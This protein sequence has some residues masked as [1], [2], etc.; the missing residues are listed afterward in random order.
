MR[1]GIAIDETWSFL[2]EIYADLQEYHKVSLFNKRSVK[3][4]FFSE[5]INRRLYRA[6]WLSFL[7]ENDVVFFEWASELLIYATQLPK[8]C[9]IVTRLH[10]YELYQWADQVNWDKVDKIILVSKAKQKEFCDRFPQQ[11]TKTLVIP[12]AISTEKFHPKPKPFGRNIGILCHL[13]PRKRVYET[14]LGFYELIQI[15]DNFSLHIAGGEHVLHRDYY[16][17]LHTIVKE[18]GLESKVTF[19][20]NITNPESWYEKIDIFL[21]NSYSEGLQVA[22]M[23]AMACECYVLSHRWEGAEELLPEENLFFTDQDLVTKILEYSAAPERVKQQRRSSLREHVIQNFDIDQTKVK[24]RNIIEEVA[25]T[26]R[27]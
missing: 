15:Q 10:R 13:T 11:A 27:N 20:G 8:T 21:S 24:I 6:D 26:Q 5:R 19:Y 14:I 23:E 3:P 16:R 25:Q 1:L 22:P 7:R 4:P 2:N 18:L 12:E 17:A 9:G